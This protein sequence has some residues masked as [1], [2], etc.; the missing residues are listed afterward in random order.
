MLLVDMISEQFLLTYNY[1]EAYVDSTILTVHTSQHSNIYPVQKNVSTRSR[2]Y[3]TS[4]KENDNTGCNLPI[5][6]NG[7]ILLILLLNLSADNV[8]KVLLLWLSLLVQVTKQSFITL[9]S[10]YMLSYHIISSSNSSLAQLLNLE[11]K[12]YIS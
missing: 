11:T 12:L 7:L 6:G 8:T 5:K 2:K 1:K 10:L 4:T 9:T 3:T